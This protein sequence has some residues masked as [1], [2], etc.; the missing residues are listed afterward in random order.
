VVQGFAVTPG[1]CGILA[2]T[3]V[4]QEVAHTPAGCGIPAE[5]HVVQEFALTPAGGWTLLQDN[6]AVGDAK[7]TLLPGASRS[8]EV[9]V[10]T[11][12]SSYATHG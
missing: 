10:R 11:F 6:I 2:E 7:V 5:T 12:K 3:Q 1:G 4:A 8:S 9:C